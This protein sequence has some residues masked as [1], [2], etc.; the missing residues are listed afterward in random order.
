MLASDLLEKLDELIEKHGDLEMVVS[1]F[2]YDKM[3]WYNED[4]EDVR[5]IKDNRGDVFKIFSVPF[6][7]E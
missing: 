2:D 6:G 7:G 4:I 3:E 1:D 5:K